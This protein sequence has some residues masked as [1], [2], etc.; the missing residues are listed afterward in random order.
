[1]DRVRDAI[2]RSAAPDGHRQTLHIRC[3]S[4]IRPVLREAGFAGEFLEYSNPFCQG[5]VPQGPDLLVR[6]TRFILDAYGAAMA[7]DEASVAAKL[8]AEEEGLTRAAGYD[9]VVIWVEHDSFDQLVLVRCLAAFAEHGMPRLLELVSANRFPGAARFIGL[10]Q[11]PPEALRLLWAARRRLG[12]EAVSFGRR[13][14]EA[15]RRPDP[16]ELAALAAQGTAD[17]PDLPN[18]LH[19]HLQELPWTRDGLSLTQRLTLEIV[20]DEGE[21]T[22]GRSFGRL[23]RER[24]PLPWMGDV[25]FLAEVDALAGAARPALAVAGPEE[26]WPQRRLSL[27]AAGLALLDGRADWLA[28]G[29]GERWVGGVQLRTQEPCWRWDDRSGMPVRR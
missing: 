15:L 18:A 12:A 21:A 22:I 8:A 4:D 5:P 6:R 9:R 7:L 11:L 27:T 20:R 24:E 2:G 25:M 19:R 14:W 17:L 26:P 16:R 28:C 3:G 23:M 13:C 10:G 1:M 29:P